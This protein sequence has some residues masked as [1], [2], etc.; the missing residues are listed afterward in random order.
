MAQTLQYVNEV[1][2]FF[3]E[4]P[5]R[6]ESVPAGPQSLPLATAKVPKRSPAGTTIICADIVLRGALESTGDIQLHGRVE[7]SVRAAG[8]VVKDTAVIE[9]DVIADD[10]TVRGSIRGSIRARKVLLCAGS[11]VEADIHYSVFAAESGARI[12]GNCRYVDDP[13]SPESADAAARGPVALGYRVQ[14]EPS[15]QEAPHP[16]VVA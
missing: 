15:S 7:G 5:F 3:R 14:A 10:V 11:R 13:L 4:G 9:G 8:L 1:L 16:E 12:E 2:D 6:D